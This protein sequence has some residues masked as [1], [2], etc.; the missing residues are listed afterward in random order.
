M[1][2]SIESKCAQCEGPIPDGRARFCSDACLAQHKR[3]KERLTYGHRH[4]YRCLQCGHYLH[5]GRHRK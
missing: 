3:E 5:L 4:E 1:P 2:V